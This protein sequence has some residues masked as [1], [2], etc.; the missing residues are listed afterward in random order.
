MRRSQIEHQALPLFTASARSLIQLDRN[1][2]IPLY[3][4]ISDALR[5][6]ISAGDLTPGMRLPTERALAQELGVNRTTVM[7]AYNELAS[8]GLIAGHV[9]RGTLV[10]RGYFSQDEDSFEQDTPAWLL[11]LAAGE[12]AVLGPDARVL[13]E[14]VATGGYREVISLASGTPPK[15]LLPAEQLQTIFMEGLSG[16]RE[17]ALGYVPVEG[18]LSLRRGLAARMRRRG[19]NVDLQNILILSGST[20]GLGLIGRFLLN[21]GDEVVA[22][23]PTYIGAIQTFRALGARVIGVPIDSEGMRVDL[24]E[25]VLSRRNP[26]L[27]YTQ[28][29]FQNPTGASMSQERRR[30]LLL[31][32]R[33]YQVPI[34]EDDP[35]GELY[36][37]GKEPQPLKALDSRDYVLYLSTFSKML[38]P[39]LRV[40]W[41]AAPEPMISRISLHKQV[42][43]LNTNAIGQWAVTEFLRRDLMDGHL[44]MLRER[45]RQRRDAM[46]QAIKTYWPAGIRVNYPH[47]GFHLWCRLPGDL[48]ARSL[49]REAAQERV[50]FLIGEP[51]YT[52]GSGHNYIRMSFAAP[53]EEQIEEAVRRIGHTMKGMLKRQSAR[54]DGDARHLERLPMI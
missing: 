40:A 16:A 12:G 14:L 8:E 27:I 3:R 21:P 34:I 17:E 18:L 25:S 42:F 47:G 23:L 54:D 38:A 53:A 24:L 32:A 30:R 4:Q 39:G 26:R 2:G 6:A 10:K 45:Y 15:E 20:Q 46:L 36:F 19:V 48:R 50:A 44:V 28:P 29:T 22:E 1:S 7:N 51:F 43:D 52:D 35:Y 5:A 31:L 9:G 49:V 13:S 11:G 33:R 37:D 41:L